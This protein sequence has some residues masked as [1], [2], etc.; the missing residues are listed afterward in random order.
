MKDL[1]VPAPCTPKWVAGSGPGTQSQLLPRPN[2][3]GA[4]LPPTPQPKPGAK[5]SIPGLPWKK[6]TILLL[7]HHP[8]NLWTETEQHKGSAGHLGTV[9]LG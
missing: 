4:T 9:N 7:E 5:T 2:I 1:T 8:E 3:L 6:L